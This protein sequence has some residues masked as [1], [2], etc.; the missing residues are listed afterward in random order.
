MTVC[1]LTGSHYS[2]SKQRC[3]KIAKES[4]LTYF[5]IMVLWLMILEWQES[6]ERMAVTYL[7]QWGTHLFKHRKMWRFT[8]AKNLIRISISYIVLKIVYE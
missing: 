1:T 7:K 4:F 6:Q 3:F 8:L 2:K 5:I